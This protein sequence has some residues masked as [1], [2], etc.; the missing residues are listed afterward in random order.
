[1]NTKRT[2]RDFIVRAATMLL[3][4][5]LTSTTV[6]ADNGYN[7][8]A[9]DGSERNTYKDD[10]IPDINVRVLNGDDIT[11]FGTN[12]GSYWYVVTGLDVKYN[13]WL[14]FKGN[15]H[16]ILKDGA[17]ITIEIND[18]NNECINSE[19]SLTIYGQSQGTGSLVILNKGGMGIYASNDITI[20][21]GSLT[22][23]SHK[24]GIVTDGDNI[25]INGGSITVTPYDQDYRGIY[26]AGNINI[27][28][29]QISATSTVTS[30]EI[31]NSSIEAFYNINLGCKKQTD[32]IFACNYKAS[33]ISINS[34]LPLIDGTNI[35]TNTTSVTTSGL[36]NKTL[37]PDL[38]GISYGNNGSSSSPYIISTPQGLQL[39]ATYVNNGEEFSGK[40]FLLGNDINMNGIALE[41]IGKKEIEPTISYFFSGIFDGNGH[42][43][44]NI[45]ISK[46]KGNV[47]LFAYLKNATVKNLILDHAIITGNYTGGIAGFNESSTITNC[48]VR[49][50]TIT[51]QYQAGAI[52]GDNDGIL[53]YNYYSGC[54]VGGSNY[55][56]G[57]GGSNGPSDI[58][59]NDGAVRANN[60]TI[61]SET[62][63]IG[64]WPT[65]NQNDEIF[66]FREFT[67][68][69]A[70][71]ICLPFVPTASNGTFYTF[72]GI[73]GTGS[74]TTAT[75]EQVNGT[76]SAN[77]PY[78]F[79]VASTG[80]VMFHG[81]AAASKSNTSAGTTTSAPWT[82]KGT[83]NEIKWNE[84][85]PPVGIYGFSA[86]AVADDGIYQGQF[87]KVGTY[88]KIR[89]LRA[90]LQ[91]GSATTRSSLSEEELP[92]RI[93]VRLVGSGETS[94][95]Q[96][97]LK[98]GEVTFDD[99]WYTLEGIRLNGKPTKQGIYVNKGKKYIIK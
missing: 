95:G 64:S 7:Y 6:W 18:K 42:T 82:F 94:I 66:F 67:G 15:T 79:K 30:N 11:E 89:P 51:G 3:M 62:E 39:L 47:G 23:K 40:S 56:V 96:L 8:I 87:V 77:I 69:S 90:Y 46:N 57:C 14:T 83:Y 4:M 16:I 71:T 53:L 21:G 88:V 32:Y 31:Y 34:D 48:I 22:V 17:Q 25:N 99:G 43:I 85:N 81:P 80:V 26:S 12:G 61:I 1:M 93:M 78:I 5:L 73:T 84:G 72:K 75:Y 36:A 54:T 20:N 55:N 28:S 76:P 86:Q 33:N 58:I 65:F 74:S 45:N 97:D 29:G 44:S 52:I 10:H 27:T 92:D 63:S 70:S 60:I 35:Y 68:N 59:A 50:A 98:T 38:F 91:Y 19:K 41:P 9:A 13:D 24:E 49:N 2:K 37:A